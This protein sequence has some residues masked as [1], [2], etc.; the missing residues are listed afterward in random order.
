[1]P[2]GDLSGHLD[3]LGGSLDGLR[4]DEGCRR[5]HPIGPMTTYRVGGA[6]SLYVR[7]QGLPELEAVAAVLAGSGAPVVVIGRGSNLL[8]ADGGFEGVAVQ[9]GDGFEEVLVDGSV[10]GGVNVVAGGGASLPVVARLTVQ[11]GLS[12]FEWAVGVPGSIG[13]AVRMN[14]GGHGSDM[15]AVLGWA[16]VVDLCDGTTRRLQ[17]DELELGYR[18]S[19]LTATQVVS[20]A[21]LELGTDGAMEGEAMLAEIIRWRRE[22]QPGGS[23]AGSVF[24]NPPGDSAGRL[25][26]LAGAKGLRIGTAQVSPKH[27]NFI[28][29]DVG[30]SAEDVRL[31]MREVRQRVADA[32]GVVLESETVLVG[33]DTPGP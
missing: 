18:H 24:T 13:G 29:A 7:P 9:L 30:G 32:H 14:A 16:D 8:V 11:S 2:D 10:E 1:M 6:A 27:A 25:I 22:N 21:G 15:A 19:V 3:D 28:Q 5:W 33:F 31:L 12:G 23:N 20:A 4:L 17:V 26:D